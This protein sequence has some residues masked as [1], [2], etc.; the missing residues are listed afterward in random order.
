MCIPPEKS[1]HNLRQTTWQMIRKLTIMRLMMITFQQL[2]CKRYCYLSVQQPWQ[3]QTLGEEVKCHILNWTVYCFSLFIISNLLFDM[4][5][6]MRWRK[7]QFGKLSPGCTA[8]CLWV[9]CIHL[10]LEL[11]TQF[12]ASNKWKKTLLMKSRH[13]PNWILGLT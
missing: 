3:L 5:L 8:D 12:P 6:W 9:F 2:A 7:L 1:Q 13:L 10:K 4:L 11:L